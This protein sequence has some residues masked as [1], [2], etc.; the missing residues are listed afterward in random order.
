MTSLMLSEL[1]LSQHSVRARVSAI[2]SR[3]RISRGVLIVFEFM[4]AAIR[5]ATESFAANIATNTWS[6]RSHSI[7]NWCQWHGHALQT[8]EDN[9]CEGRGIVKDAMGD[10]DILRFYIR[11]HAGLNIKALRFKVEIEKISKVSVIHW[12]V[13]ML[14]DMCIYLSLAGRFQACRCIV[15]TEFNDSGVGA[16]DRA[17]HWCAGKSIELLG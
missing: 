13:V 10:W 2:L 11:E 14:S 15:G 12:L 5:R 7:G 4:A 16:Q 17:E 3:T 6:D 8:P 1:I 9:W